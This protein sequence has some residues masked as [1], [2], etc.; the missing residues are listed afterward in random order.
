VLQIITS[1]LQSQAT[2][3]AHHAAWFSVAAEQKC[4]VNWLFIVNLPHPIL[5]AKY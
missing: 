1:Q 5:K 3:H 2:V 4:D